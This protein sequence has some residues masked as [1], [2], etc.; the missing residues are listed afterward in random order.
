MKYEGYL[1]SDQT[2][3]RCIQTRAFAA[4]QYAELVAWL[5][6]ADFARR[7]R[8]SAT[9]VLPSLV[10]A[11]CRLYFWACALPELGPQPGEV[12]IRLMPW[13]PAVLVGTH[14]ALVAVILGIG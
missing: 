3:D 1:P 5:Y 12:Q 9:F 10:Q 13:F 4:T 7:R 11:A 2:G 14:V 6:M 8:A